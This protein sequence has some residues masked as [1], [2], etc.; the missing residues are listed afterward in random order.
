MWGPTSRKE[1]LDNVTKREERERQ[2]EK[3]T[4][5]ICAQYYDRTKS[6]VWSF[7]VCTKCILV[8]LIASL[9]MKSYLCIYLFAYI[10]TTMPCQ[11]HSNLMDSYWWENNSVY[12]NSVVMASIAIT[13]CVMYCWTC[14]CYWLLSY[15][16]FKKCLLIIFLVPLLWRFSFLL[17][18]SKTWSCW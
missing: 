17:G 7:Y 1:D 18:C 6:A 10:L 11:S 12:N 2:A 5:N 3:G 4:I 13:K 15:C 16:H 14:T 8:T 9:I